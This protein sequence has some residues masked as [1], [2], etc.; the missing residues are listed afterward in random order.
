MGNLV[1]TTPG[2]LAAREAELLDRQGIVSGNLLVLSDHVFTDTLTAFAAYV[3]PTGN[4]GMTEYDVY[5]RFGDPEL[6]IIDEI[7]VQM[8]SDFERMVLTS[9]ADIRSRNCRPT[10]IV[11]NLNPEEILGLVGERMFDRLVGFGANIVKMRGASMRMAV[12]Q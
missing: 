11:S 8:G 1:K 9:I 6:L 12:A 4:D 10:I 5:A 3:D 7:G 2:E